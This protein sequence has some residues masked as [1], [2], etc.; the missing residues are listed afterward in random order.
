[1]DINKQD[2]KSHHSDEDSFSD[3]DCY[4]AMGKITE[5]YHFG[6][7]PQNEFKDSIKS[8]HVSLAN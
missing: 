1:M 2:R 4:V 7:F 6:T 8:W 5:Y 3:E